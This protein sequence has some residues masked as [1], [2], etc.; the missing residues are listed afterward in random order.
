MEPISSITLTFNEEERIPALME[1]LKGVDEIIIID[2]ESTDNTV[3]LAT[4][5]GARVIVRPLKIN[6]ATQD[7][8][9]DFTAKYGFKP[10]FTPETKLLDFELKESLEYATHDW[11]FWPDADEIV[12]W[13]LPEIRK[14]LPLC[15]QVGYKFIHDHHSDGTPAYTLMHNK[16]FR[17]SKSYWWGRVHECLVG[18]GEIRKIDTDKMRVDHWRKPKPYHADYLP[19]LEYTVIKDGGP[20]N[21]WYLAREYAD[22]GL[23]EKSLK[24]YDEYLKIGTDRSMI[25]EAYRRMAGCGWYL[26]KDNGDYSRKFCIRAIAINPDFKQA[27]L[28]M[29][30]YTGEGQSEYWK[31]YAEVATDNNVTFKTH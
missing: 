26:H 30:E 29:S 20:R 23:Y 4:E 16:L 31:R 6:Y 5:L 14:L 12:T 2:H 8:M 28:D 9:F 3:K 21:L 24:L 1:S 10:S 13:D 17:K 15:D 7:D 22:V 11:V 27:L 18:Y 19:K 25:A